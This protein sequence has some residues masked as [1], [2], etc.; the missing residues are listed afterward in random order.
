MQGR[1]DIFPPVSRL[2]LRTE[3]PRQ[4]GREE[5]LR[6]QRRVSEDGTGEL[7]PYGHQGSG[8]ISSLPWSTGLARLPADVLV[9]DKDRVAYY[10]LRHW[11]A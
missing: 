6:V 2:P 10:D 1:A 4:D 5:F 8:V 3:H 7:V 9:Q 11:L